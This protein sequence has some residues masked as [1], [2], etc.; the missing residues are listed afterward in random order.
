MT[1]VVG[2]RRPALATVVA[3]AGCA[4]LVARPLFLFST[5]RAV[6]LFAALLAVGLLWPS[7]V[8]YSA[9]SWRSVAPGTAWV[10]LALGV[11][12]F[13]VGRVVGGGHAPMPLAGRFIVLNTLAAV[14]EEAF[15]R[16]LVYGAFE[17]H[18]AALAVV[19]SALLF[20][21]VHVT[22]YGWWVLPLDLAAG[23]VFSWQRWATGRWTV[24]AATHV[25]A[26]VLVVL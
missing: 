6:V 7:R 25:V 2:V 17:R 12:A 15:F 8:R 24:P 5:M 23:L 4:A 20:A 13:A 10:V 22:V 3:A 16:R 18:G 19:G 11:A 14:A 26:N 9:S 1:A 21:V